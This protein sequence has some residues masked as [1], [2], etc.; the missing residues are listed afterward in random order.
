MVRYGPG[1]ERPGEP[2]WTQSVQHELSGPERGAI[3]VEMLVRL[4]A[5]EKENDRGDS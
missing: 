2:G 4:L 5:E 3:P 1:R